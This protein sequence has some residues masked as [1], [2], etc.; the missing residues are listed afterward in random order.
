M[1]CSLIVIISQVSSFELIWQVDLPGWAQMPIIKD[2]IVYSVW[3][4]QKGT[5]SAIDLQT[6]QVLRTIDNVGQ[7]TAPFIVGNRI[8]SYDNN[9][10]E[11]D[12]NTFQLIRTINIPDSSYTENIPYDE[13]TGYFFARQA[14]QS[15]YKGKLSAFRLSDGQVMWSFPANFKGGFN[16]DQSP[17]VV[18]DSVFLFGCNAYWE[19]YDIV[20]RLINTQVS[21]YGQPNYP[22]QV[23][24]GTITRYT[25]RIMMFSISVKVGMTDQAISMQ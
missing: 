8:Y 3:N 6:G 24:A 15:E 20:Y 5:L 17:I 1:I 11:I 10:H 18:G 9:M 16:C 4:G 12:L 25:M 14:K 21:R 7:A 23:G 2:G 13:E 19:G 22:L